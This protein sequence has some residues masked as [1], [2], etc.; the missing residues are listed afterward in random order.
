MLGVT[1]GA[2]ATYGTMAK[3][4]QPNFSADADEDFGQEIHGR[5]SI[6]YYAFS[7]AK[8]TDLWS[9]TA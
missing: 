9:C 7:P 5:V 3:Y 2:D 8:S 4:L 6:S 1:A